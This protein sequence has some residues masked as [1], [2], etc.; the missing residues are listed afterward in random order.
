ML[1][2][3][4]VFVADWVDVTRHRN[5]HGHDHLTA[6]SAL[7]RGSALATTLPLRVVINHTEEHLCSCTLRA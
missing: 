6:R 5:D 1:H 4:F 2:G 3:A 7:A